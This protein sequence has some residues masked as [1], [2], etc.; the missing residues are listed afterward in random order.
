MN[1]HKQS[2]ILLAATAASAALIAGCKVGPDY[3]S[4]TTQIGANWV[5]PTGNAAPTTQPVTSTRWWQ[6]FNDPE[7]DSLVERAANANL[8]LRLAGARVREARAL[9]RFAGADEYPE[10]NVGGSY[11]HSRNAFAVGGASGST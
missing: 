8:D 3:K 1:T 11:S 6:T 4:P 9:R 2:L 5:E 7:L 10:V